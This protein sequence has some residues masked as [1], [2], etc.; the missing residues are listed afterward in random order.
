MVARSKA[1]SWH[2]FI[3]GQR[4]R[5]LIET[6]GATAGEEEIIQAPG[7]LATI[8][9]LANF[10]KFQGEGVDVVVGEGPR[11]ICNSFDERDLEAIGVVPFAR[12]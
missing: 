6:Q 2:G 5:I 8:T 10:G 7:T 11:A 9:G 3:A 12:I 1:S 4:V